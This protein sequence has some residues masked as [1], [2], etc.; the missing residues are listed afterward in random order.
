MPLLHILLTAA[1]IAAAAGGTWG[2]DRLMDR[3]ARLAEPPAGET[4]AEVAEE[5]EKDSRLLY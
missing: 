5:D 2:M 3:Y 1:S 4:L